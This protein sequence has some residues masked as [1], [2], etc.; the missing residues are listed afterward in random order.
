MSESTKPGKVLVSTSHGR[1]HFPEI[2]QSSLADKSIIGFDRYGRV[3][4]AVVP[5]EAVRMLAGFQESVDEDVQVRV[6]RAALALLREASGEAE[7][8]G[9]T[10]DE[11][12]AAKPVS[13]I[14]AR[15][16]AKRAKA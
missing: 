10:A 11:A 8:L 16:R 6:K 7:R 9:L 13:E 15:G 2:L 1:T 4:G 5:I 12:Q 3:V 14:A